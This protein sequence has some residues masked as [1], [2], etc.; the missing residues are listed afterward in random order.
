M[1]Y[2]KMSAPSSQEFQKNLLKDLEQL[3]KKAI[4]INATKCYNERS[5]I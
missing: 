4:Y 5:L 2:K 3:L 1:C